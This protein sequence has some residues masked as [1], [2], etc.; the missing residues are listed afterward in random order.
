MNIIN[1]ERV[2]VRH[3]NSIKK[4]QNRENTLNLMSCAEK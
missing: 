4:T 2:E 3:V 1:K